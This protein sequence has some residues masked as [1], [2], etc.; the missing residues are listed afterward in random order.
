MN[1]VLHTR[2]LV[3]RGAEVVGHVWERWGR[4]IG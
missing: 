4:R 1:L 3:Q 2:S